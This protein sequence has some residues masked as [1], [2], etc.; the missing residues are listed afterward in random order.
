MLPAIEAP[1]QK[2]PAIINRA[3]G[4]TKIYTLAV[5]L[6]GQQ[7]NPV[8]GVR[9]NGHPNL[10]RFHLVALPRMQEQRL[11]APAAFG[12]AVAGYFRLAGCRQLSF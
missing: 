10:V 5:L 8:A 9:V 6:R 11:F 1:A 2:W 3:T 4:I 7:E 12:T